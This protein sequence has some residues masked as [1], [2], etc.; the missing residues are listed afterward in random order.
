[1][2]EIG[3]SSFKHLFL[4]RD[5]DFLGHMKRRQSPQNLSDTP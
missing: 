3:V 1:M 2:E 5:G 4:L